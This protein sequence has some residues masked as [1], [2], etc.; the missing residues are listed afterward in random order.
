MQIDQVSDMFVSEK[1]LALDGGLRLVE[2][3]AHWTYWLV[4]TRIEPNT[5]RR[6][7]PVR[8]FLILR[9][10]G[11]LGATFR[12]SRRRIRGGARLENANRGV[13]FGRAWLFW[14]L[15]SDAN[16]FIVMCRFS[17]LRFL[18]RLTFRDDLPTLRVIFQFS[19]QDARN[20]V[21]PCACTS[22]MAGGLLTLKSTSRDSA[23]FSA[24][25]FLFCAVFF[26]PRS[27]LSF[28]LFLRSSTSF[29]SSRNYK[30]E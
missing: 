12:R 3:A 10:D 23:F 5:A 20:N 11:R 8:I 1:A 19:L 9:L 22:V 17:L 21:R 16:V 24:L 29:S 18:G 14:S 30:K 4:H 2:V 13:G 28:A 27:L 15:W 26:E 25:L 6:F 7:T